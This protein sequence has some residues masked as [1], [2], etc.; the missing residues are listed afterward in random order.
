MPFSWTFPK[1]SIKSLIVDFSHKLANNGL[2]SQLLN[3][4]KDFLIGRS[5]TAILEGHNSN[6]SEVLSGVP[7]GTV[8][9]TLLLPAT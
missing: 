9:A 1:H 5:Q 6:S 3:W 4:M 2:C 7:Q 8:L